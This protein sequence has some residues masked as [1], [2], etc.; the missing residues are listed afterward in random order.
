M[1]L[2]SRI[3]VVCAE[4]NAPLMRRPLRPTDDALIENFFCNTTCK[5]LWQK[6]QKPVDEA[7]LRQKYL[8][9][10]LGAP[11]IAKLVDRNSKQ[12]WRW[13]KGYGIPTRPRGCNAATN[14]QHGRTPGFKLTEAHKDGLRAA[15]LR[16]GRYPKAADGSP[17]WK[18]KSGNLHPAWNGGHTP[19]RQAFYASEAW[20]IAR[21][22]A[23]TAA[24]GKCQRCG[25][26]D[27][28][29]VHH[30]FPFPIVHLRS[31]TWNLR[32]LCAMCHR[33][34]HS[35]ANGNREFLPPFGVYRFADGREL[36]MSY[37]PRRPVT[38]PRWLCS[39]S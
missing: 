14:L 9:D 27:E 37:R 22:D 30:V 34:V 35:G 26:K 1:A 17:Y 36:R 29:H 6:R 3:P 4:C 2:N 33:F 24:G 25:S 7:W 11:D 8:Q 15:R 31:V 18:G 28:L 23:Y 16:D 20:A 12:V 32:V 10:G 13:L 5:G 38:L 19:E 39:K 21:R